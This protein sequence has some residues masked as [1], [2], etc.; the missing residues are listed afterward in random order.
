M[1]VTDRWGGAPLQLLCVH[2]V[3]PVRPAPQPQGRPRAPGARTDLQP[4]PTMGRGSTKSERKT[5]L[6]VAVVP[7]SEALRDAGSEDQARKWEKLADVPTRRSP[8]RRTHST[9]NSVPCGELTIAKMVPGSWHQALGPPCPRIA[10]RW[11]DKEL[12]ELVA[13]WPTNSAKQIAILCT[14]RARPYAARRSDCAP[15]ACCRTAAG[16]S[17]LT[18]IRERRNS[19]PVRNQGS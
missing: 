6:E 14:V 13:P 11:T 2:S 16:P 10:M 17:I 8:I 15:R 19:A 12:R 5:G 9:N 3:R 18:S 1:C 7:K 4:V